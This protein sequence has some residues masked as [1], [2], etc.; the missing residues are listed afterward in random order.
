MANYINQD[1]KI[2]KETLGANFESIHLF[3][4]IV[5]GSKNPNDIDVMVRV[6]EKRNSVELL[7]KLSQLNIPIGYVAAG[8]YDSP[9]KDCKNKYDI[10][11]I[12]DNEINGY[13]YQRNKLDFIKIL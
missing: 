1:F 2:I 10:V 4:S 5:K 11:I 13:F 6:K 7:E 3:G 12:S 9:I 8:R